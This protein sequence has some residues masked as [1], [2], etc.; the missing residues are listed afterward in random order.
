MAPSGLP[1][2]FPVKPPTKG[3]YPKNR[4]TQVATTAFTVLQEL[5]DV[6]RVQ[7][8][9]V[10][11]G[12]STLDLG[13]T[14]DGQNPAPLSNHEKSLF[15]GICRGVVISGLL[16]WCRTSSIHSSARPSGK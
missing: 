12:I 2:S 1:P 10:L 6:G 13:H 9:A 15:V 4:Q 14:A 3:G 16:R 11:A 5:R 8:L 7:A